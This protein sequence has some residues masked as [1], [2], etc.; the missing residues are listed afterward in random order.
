MGGVRVQCDPSHSTPPYNILSVS[1]GLEPV[2]VENI[3]DGEE[4]KTDV[5]AIE[6]FVH[7]LKPENVVCVLTTTSCFAPRAVD[8]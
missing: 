5:V 2:V 4:L 7:D 3:L 6:K 8:R 1:T